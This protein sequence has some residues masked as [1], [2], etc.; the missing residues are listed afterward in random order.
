MVLTPFH[1]EAPSQSSFSVA[2]RS[3]SFVSSRSQDS[4]LAQNEE[5]RPSLP[6]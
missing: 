1:D 3:R 6:I 5:Y 2:E 4:T